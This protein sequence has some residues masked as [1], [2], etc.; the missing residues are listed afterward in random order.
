MEH[1]RKIP[2][3]EFFSKKIRNF[4]S[5]TETRFRKLIQIYRDC[6]AKKNSSRPKEFVGKL[7]KK[8]R[9]KLE[10]NKIPYSRVS[11]I[12]SSFLVTCILVRATRLPK[13]RSVHAR[14]TEIE[15]IY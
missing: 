2:A 4:Y 9:E 3:L 11:M 12:E 10:K 1:I 15:E 5:L 13:I 14:M 8:E 7:E 6:T